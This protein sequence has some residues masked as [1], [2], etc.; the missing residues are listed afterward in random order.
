MQ[1]KIGFGSVDEWMDHLVP[2]RTS[3]EWPRDEGRPW[4]GWKFYLRFEPD[5]I[6]FE[7]L[8]EWGADHFTGEWTLGDPARS[9]YPTLY[10]NDPVDAVKVKLAWAVERDEWERR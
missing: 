9:Q 10:F 8:A 7:D 5:L 6:T 3:R 1:A 4:Q 2:D